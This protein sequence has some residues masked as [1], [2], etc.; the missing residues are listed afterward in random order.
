MNMGLL[1]GQFTESD[2]YVANP[3]C[4]AHDVH[5]ARMGPILFFVCGAACTTSHLSD[6]VNRPSK[7][8][9]VTEEPFRSGQRSRLQLQARRQGQLGPGPGYASRVQASFTSKF[10]L[11][12]VGAWKLSSGA[13]FMRHTWLI[14]G[15]IQFYKFGFLGHLWNVFMKVILLLLITF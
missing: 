13:D 9:N 6:R 5:T 10:M 8:T 2:R 1:E 15:K 4:T 12:Q 3:C 14:Y 7:A 11:C